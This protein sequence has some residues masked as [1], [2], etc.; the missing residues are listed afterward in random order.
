MLLQN[1][2]S[3]ASLDLSL[4]VPTLSKAIQN[5]F[6][7]WSFMDWLSVWM[8]SEFIN[9]TVSW[10]FCT[11]QYKEFTNNCHVFMVKPRFY[12]RMLF[13]TPTVLK[14]STIKSCQSYYC[15]GYLFWH[16]CLQT[17]QFPFLD[18]SP[19]IIPSLTQPMEYFFAWNQCTTGI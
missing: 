11:S 6:L 19:E 12:G 13:L 9:P 17:S 18:N 7:K 5:F 1:I 3:T 14:I 4:K 15:Q 2:V 8:A 16:T 10:E